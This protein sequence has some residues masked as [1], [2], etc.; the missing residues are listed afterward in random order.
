M[1]NNINFEPKDRYRYLL[2]IDIG[3]KHLGLLLLQCEQNFN[4]D[5]IVWFELIDITKFHHLDL[6]SKLQC[7]LEHTNTIADWLDHIFF[8]HKEL[9]DVCEYILIERQPLQGH[10]SIEQLIFYRFRNKSKLVHPR[11]VHKFF[12]W[13]SK[14]DYDARKIKSQDIFYY[15]LKKTKR[16]WI[17]NSYNDLSRK[18]DISDAYLQAVYFCHLRS[19]EFHLANRSEIKL[20]EN[21]IFFEKF[22]YT[23][24]SIY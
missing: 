9:F 6:N 16:T 21:E 24:Q 5:D 22:R 20:T 18:H 3:I 13:D 15:R 2:S 1:D 23:Q 4:I 12:G 17:V 7:K 10:V 11:S 8:L 19:T 14:V